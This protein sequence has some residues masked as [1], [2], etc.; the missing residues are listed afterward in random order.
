MGP[1]LK[2]GMGE[3]ETSGTENELQSRPNKAKIRQKKDNIIRFNIL[4]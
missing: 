1:E 2:R 3:H 4:K